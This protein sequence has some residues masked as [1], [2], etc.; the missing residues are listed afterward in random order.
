MRFSDFDVALVL[1]G[2]AALGA[3]QGGV[4]EGLHE[5]GLLPGHVVGTSI[6]AIN[7][8]LIAGNRPDER[9]AKLRRFWDRVTESVGSL[10]AVEH[11]RLRRAQAHLA[12][13]RTK[14]LG[15]PGFLAPQWLEALSPIRAWRS[16]GLSDLTPML[17]NLG[18][19][20]DFPGPGHD[21][22][23]LTIQTTDLATGAP[24]RFDSGELQLAPA[25]VRASASL[26]PDFPP[27]E[28]EG[29]LLCDGSFSE[30]LPLRA[31]LGALPK[32]PLLCIAV[33]LMPS[34]GE[35]HWSLDGMLERQLNLQFASQTR[36]LIEAVT[37]ELTLAAE[38]IGTSAPPVVLAHLVYR[39]QDDAGSQKTYDFSRRSIA[40]RWE[41]GLNDARAMIAALTAA[42]MPTDGGLT[43]RR[44][45]EAGMAAPSIHAKAA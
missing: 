17:E 30:N 14:L 28:V 23:Q 10:P 5:A 25:H 24:V 13:L 19:L 9:V 27:T 41:L 29:R 16:P 6:G 43:I 35:P 1:S 20:V 32:R 22:V 21:G 36:A 15:R 2:G 31:V 26:I 18:E 3:Y 44:F 42:P 45:P 39:G 38:R 33:D 12:G 7:G 40:G 11:G 37:A 4:Y 8:T 34:E